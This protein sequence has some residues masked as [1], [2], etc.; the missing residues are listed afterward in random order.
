M[1]LGESVEVSMHATEA[2]TLLYCSIMRLF[3]VHGWY[4]DVWIVLFFLLYPIFV[5]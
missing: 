2:I 3:Y 5:V 4:V 1:R